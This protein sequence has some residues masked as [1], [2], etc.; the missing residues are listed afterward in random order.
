MR[1]FAVR[2]PAIMN[3]D[4]RGPNPKISNVL[5]SNGWVQDEKRN[6]FLA[7][8]DEGKEQRKYFS[9][10]IVYIHLLYIGEKAN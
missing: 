1:T 4:R 2:L 6:W 8:P 3:Y 7:H 10:T 5:V 9:N